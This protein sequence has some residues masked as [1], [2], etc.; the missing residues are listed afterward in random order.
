MSELFTRGSVG[1]RQVTAASTRQADLKKLGFR[2]QG[3]AVVEVIPSGLF[4]AVR[5]RVF[6]RRGLKRDVSKNFKT[7]NE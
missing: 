1:V 5:R 4:W 2:S 6:T 7:A 3:L